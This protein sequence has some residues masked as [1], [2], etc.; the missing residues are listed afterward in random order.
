M[1][2]RRVENGERRDWGDKNVAL[3]VKKP[4]SAILCRPGA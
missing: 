4:V 1:F 2:E 3:V